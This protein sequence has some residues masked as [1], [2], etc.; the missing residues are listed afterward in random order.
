[1]RRSTEVLIGAGAVALQGPF[2]AYLSGQP[3]WGTALLSVGFLATAAGLCRH[4]S[5]PSRAQGSGRILSLSLGSLGMLVGWYMDAGFHPLV[6][7]GI[8]LCGCAD[9]PAG[10][11]L[12]SG[13]HWMQSLMLASCAMGAVAARGRAGIFSLSASG[14]LLLSCAL[15]LAAMAAAGWAEGRLRI[16]NPSLGLV[17]SYLAMAAGMACGSAVAARLP[18]LMSPAPPARPLVSRRS[19]ATP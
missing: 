12:V 16:E 18:R 19:G 2:L 5:P 9:S 6:G 11:G 10:L 8:C 1:M 4:A 3:A 13:L 14:N 15:M 7:H 17:L